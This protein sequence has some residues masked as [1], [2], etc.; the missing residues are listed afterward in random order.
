MTAPGSC[1]TLR[2]RSTVRLSL[3]LA[4]QLCAAP[5]LALPGK[6]SA[7]KDWSGGNPSKY[8]V[9]M[10]LLRGDGAPHHSRL[11]WF[12]GQPLGVFN[13]GEWGWRSI[14]SGFVH[15]PDSNFVALPVALPGMNIF[16][17]G[18][19]TMGDGR[20]LLAAGTDTLVGIYGDIESRIFTPGAGTAGGTWSTTGLLADWRWYPSVTAMSTGDAFVAGGSRYR[21]QRTLFGRRNGSQ[22]SSPTGD[23]LYRF[24]PVNGGAW[25]P[26]VRPQGWVNDADRPEPR[27]AQSLVEMGGVQG[28]G[29]QVLFGGRKADNQALND[30]WMLERDDENELAADSRYRWTRR[31]IVGE[32]PALRSDHSAIVS[33]YLGWMVI[34]GG[35]GNDSLPRSDVHVLSKG[36]S[37]EWDQVTP[38]GTGPTARFGHSAVY[39]SMA[40]TGDGQVRRMIVVGGASA[41]NQPADA[42]MKVW[43]L[44]LDVDPPAWS[45]LTAASGSEGPPAPRY[46]QGMALDDAPP[47]APPG[48]GSGQ[49]AFMYGGALGNN[50]FSGELWELWLLSDGKYRWKLK[51]ATGASPGSRARHSLT[52]D[53][54]PRPAGAYPG[55]L[56]VFGGENESGF[57]NDSV[58]AMHPWPSPTTSAWVS[59]KSAGFSL[60]GH[61]MVL[62][63]YG[64][65][66]RLPEV[67]DRA[68]NSYRG[69]SGAPLHWRDTYPLNFSTPGGTTAAGRIFNVGPERYSYRLDIDTPYQASGPWEKL[70]TA[71]SRFLPQSAV[72]FLPGKI[73]V[74]GGTSTAFAVVGTTKWLDATA[75]SPVWQDSTDMGARFYHNLVLLPN[76][77]VLAVGGVPTRSQTDTTSATKRPRLWDPVTHSWNGATEL[78]EE[79]VARNYH[80]TALLLPD[81]R[82]VSASGEGHGN[83]YF[84]QIYSPPYLFK[85]ADTLALCPKL[86]DAPQRIRYGKNFSICMPY[87]TYGQTA[88][89][90]RPGAVTHGFDENQHYVPL[91]VVD[92]TIDYGQRRVLAAPADSFVAPPGDYLLFVLNV[93]GVPAVARWVRLGSEWNSGDTTPP[94]TPSD[95]LAEIVSLNS[96]TVTWT[97]PGDDGAS[98]QAWQYDLRYST[99]PSTPFEQMTPVSGAASCAGFSQSHKVTGLQSCTY[100]YF[101]LRVADESGNYSGVTGQTSARTSCTAGGGGGDRAVETAGRSDGG[102][103]LQASL[104]GS[105]GHE[106]NSAAGGAATILVAEV[107]PGQSDLRWKITR[108]ERS[109]V[110]DL[111][112]SDTTGTIVQKWTPETG[113]RTRLKFGTQEGSL[114]IRSLAGDRSRILQIDPGGIQ[115]IIAEP[116]GFELL[117]A[118][119]TTHGDLYS[120]S[121]SSV[122]VEPSLAPDDTLELVFRTSTLSESP[123]LDDCFFV[124][125]PDPGVTP[126]RGRPVVAPPAMAFGLRPNRPNPFT[127]ITTFSFALPERSQ[128]RFDIFDMQGRRVRVVTD[129]PFEAGEHELAWDRRTASGALVR[130]G[131]YF[132][133]IE[134]GVHRAHR[135][136]V[137]LP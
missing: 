31:T 77:K 21:H 30:V 137:V 119:H 65:L 83:K 15:W 123:N 133:R 63:A 129:R 13:G 108:C 118:T 27:F 78:A 16:C 113:W 19:A 86:S 104:R 90:I 60:S 38:A 6:W 64:A 71:D 11:M 20:A 9:H 122:I 84:A 114:G 28:F 68:T 107:S 132:Y 75:A 40:I 42:S 131:V 70:T 39:N 51:S 76:G 10:M 116:P 32:S 117:S 54:I 87:L 92:T 125:G 43:A 7:I 102:I 36:T 3:L 96:I 80:S 91:A 69:L 112:S 34:F 44:R 53:P 135:R 14:D 18:H 97:A 134:A 121:A 109:A 8:A 25:D 23:S 74:A 58:Y 67:F 57:A 37:Y 17:S 46:W 88:C 115:R 126:A 45:E 82:V 52:Y 61:T 98:G 62:E 1:S 47:V 110:S 95:F 41:P 24:A 4:Q 94:D 85:N 55:W 105:A 101:R 130:P 50:Q 73:M 49:V 35:L 93:S 29:F 100:Y 81:A 72:Q 2:F 99:S 22:P 56:F 33:P 59:W 106:A 66:S 79:A 128:V 89:L 120:D 48:G 127:S 124:L 12:Q 136:M 111:G 103:A 26:A 5:S